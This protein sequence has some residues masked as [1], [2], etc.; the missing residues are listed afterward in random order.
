MKKKTFVWRKPENIRIAL[1]RFLRRVG[2]PE[3]I[4][5][6]NLWQHWQMVMGPDIGSLASPLGS[7]HGILLLG[8]EDAMTLQDIS[9]MQHEIL[10]RA[11]AFMGQE[12]FTGIKVHLTLDKSPLDQAAQSK[13][14]TPVHLPTIELSGKYLQDMPEDSPVARCYALFVQHSSKS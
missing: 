5:L 13:E 3:Y 1:E 4:L 9:Y 2:K 10:E 8:G 11:N 6:N 7:K 14:F 12:Y